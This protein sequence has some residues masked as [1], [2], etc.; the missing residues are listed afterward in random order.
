MSRFWSIFIGSH[1]KTKKRCKKK[2]MK[3][4]NIYKHVN[5]IT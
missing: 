4:P 1:G 3:S 2:T 5:I